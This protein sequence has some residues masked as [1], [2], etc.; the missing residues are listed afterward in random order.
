MKQ[1]IKPLDPLAYG[2]YNINNSAQAWHT[3]ITKILNNN[4]ISTA[5]LL[6]AASHTARNTR[7]RATKSPT[8]STMPPDSLA[9]TTIWLTQF[10]SAMCLFYLSF[11]RQH[12]PALWL[13]RITSPRANSRK[14]SRNITY[15]HFKKRQNATH[16]INN[17]RISIKTETEDLLPKIPP[18]W[19]TPSTLRYK[20]QFSKY[21]YQNNT[22]YHAMCMNACLDPQDVLRAAFP[23]LSI[24]R[25]SNW[26]T[27]PSSISAPMPSP[28]SLAVTD[29]YFHDSPRR[30]WFRDDSLIK[31]LKTSL[32][33]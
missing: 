5:I 12:T 9:V 20:P 19:Q 14:Y 15:K 8:L 21:K 23:I 22:F 4:L 28:A 2:T 25:P 33:L 13:A 11:V 3:T 31:T 1:N 24:G 18:Y 17:K 10:V 29:C 32:P 30:R 27:S 7:L 16:N 6:W 26:S